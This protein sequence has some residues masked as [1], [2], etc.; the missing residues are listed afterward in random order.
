MIRVKD[1]YMLLPALSIYAGL[2]GC[3]SEQVLITDPTVAV[4]HISKG[5]QSLDLFPGRYLS[6][7]F[8]ANSEH[9][10]TRDPLLQVRAELFKDGR[11][12]GSSIA[13]GPYVISNNQIDER[14]FNGQRYIAFDFSNLMVESDHGEISVALAESDFDTVEFQLRY[15]LMGTGFKFISNPVSF[16]KT[17]IL[18]SLKLLPVKYE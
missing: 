18:N 16:S 8:S 15:P 5:N 12:V 6:I 17:E 7:A 9:I 4:A 11:S 10:D 1:I 2:S 13:M 3:A 14:H